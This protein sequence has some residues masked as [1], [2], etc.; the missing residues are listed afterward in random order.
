M[1]ISIII[2]S[3]LFSTLFFSFFEFCLPELK[4]TLPYVLTSSR[5]SSSVTCFSTFLRIYFISIF[6][7]SRPPVVVWVSQL[8]KTSSNKTIENLLPNSRLT[9]L[10]CSYGLIWK[11]VVKTYLISWFRFVCSLFLSVVAPHSLSVLIGFSFYLSLSSRCCY[12][13]GSFG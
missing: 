3:L 10:V 12:V 1:F 6:G 9:H 2:L 8:L 5:R 11:Y 7:C 13:V 4:E